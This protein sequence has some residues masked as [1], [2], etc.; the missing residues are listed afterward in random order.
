MTKPAPI[1]GFDCVAMKQ[2]GGVRIY[3]EVKD[4]SREERLGYWKRMNDEYWLRR[5][6]Q[7][8]RLP[9]VHTS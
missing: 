1:Q 6:G 9:P 2:S 8:K 5:D 4:L 7:S 3:E